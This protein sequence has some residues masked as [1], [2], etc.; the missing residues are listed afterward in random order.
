MSRSTTMILTLFKK[1]PLVLVLMAV[2][3][4]G[5]A[6]RGGVVSSKGDVAAGHTAHESEPTTETVWTCSMHPQIRMS[7]PGKCPLCEMDLV[8]AATPAP[9]K[10]RLV[11][12]KPK[13]GCSMLCLP[14]MDEPGKCPI[15]GMN[16]VEI[17]DDMSMGGDD[18]S[19]GPTLT[20]SPAAQRLAEIRVAPVVRKF[21]QAE[22][23]MVG[24]V[25]FDETR[26]AY[27][28]AWIPGR[29]DRLYADFTG[30]TVNAGD[31]LAE[32]Y[33]PELYSAQAELIQAIRSVKELADSDIVNLRSGA[34]AT[35]DAVRERL[36]LWGMTAQ[37]IEDIERRGKPS[38]HMTF[39]APL[40]G[41]IIHK[42]AFEGMYVQTGTR[43]YTIADLSKLWIKL[44]AY[45]SDLVW[46]RYGQSVEIVAEAYPGE[47][48]HARIAFIAPVLNPRT[49]T[50][51]VRLN[52]DNAEGRL[53]PEMLVRATVR[54]TVA[55]GGRIV[56]ISLAGK[57]MC[58][59]H[60]EVVREEP[61]ECEL[62]GMKLKRT[63]EL[64]Y[65]PLDAS[66]QEAP[67]VIPASAPLI[68][69][70]RAVVYVAV[71]DHPGTY[72]GRE[73]VLGP[74]AGDFYLVRRGLREGE[75]VVVHGNFKLDSA[76]QL[77]A[78]PSMMNP[79]GGVAAPEHHY[80][81]G[82]QEHGMD[83]R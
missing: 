16:M 17:E 70:K 69:G 78:K 52:V 65:V 68:T 11:K 33:S 58:S 73:V 39:F 47:V 74:R 24:K 23:R 61:G 71:P 27:I 31:H 50:V 43:I 44:D 22:I 62:C 15:C 79:G 12:K 28:T 66:Q 51:K 4:L 26:M 76:M 46:L 14:P 56:D 35:V 64:G 77:R 72:Q 9:E 34:Q 1:T 10:I 59:M 38:D 6:F 57:W 55:A 49:R 20:L 36:R 5:Y 45:E 41:I 83:D 30:M 42:D 2:F 82:S 80:G 13:Y 3:A 18:D 8:P 29:L 54:S 37:Q 21:V 81:G 60:P 63:E 19:Q 40:G 7:E 32:F 75:S 25:D 67:L 48:F 53:K